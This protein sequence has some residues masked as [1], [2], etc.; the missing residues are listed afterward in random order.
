MLRKLML[1]GL[2][3]ASSI[4]A[5]A[6]F[7]M[8]LVADNGPSTAPNRKVHRFD[9]QTGVYLGSF[10]FFNSNIQ[11]LALDQST[12]SV[13]VFASNQVISRYDYNTGNLISTFAAGNAGQFF[14]TVRPD[15]ARQA[16]FDGYN[17]FIV[18]G[19]PDP[20]SIGITGTSTGVVYRSGIWASN[21]TLYAFDG[22]GSKFL[23]VTM[24]AA[25]NTGA[26]TAATVS[27]GGLGYGQISR[28]GGTNKFVMGG[29]SGFYTFDPTANT[30]S[31]IGVAGPHVASATAHDGFYL[32]SGP[33]NSGEILMYDRLY[34][35]RTTFGNGILSNPVAM[36]T[37]LA[38]EPGSFVALLAGL[39]IVLRRRRRS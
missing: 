10:G 32:T 17:N 28:I 12:N 15:F 8:L 30:G 19:F 6:S 20:G 13:Y 25:G 37:V 3:V 39:A 1:A 18:Q 14:P 16:Y 4:P 5:W 31:W 24:N 29:S 2:V 33:T 22:A 36:A 7:E 21:D 27:L 23:T 11:S 35:Y 34:N 38:P 26:V 9:P